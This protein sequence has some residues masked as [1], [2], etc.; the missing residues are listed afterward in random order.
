LLRYSPE[1]VTTSGYA[2]GIATGIAF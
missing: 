1:P 2:L